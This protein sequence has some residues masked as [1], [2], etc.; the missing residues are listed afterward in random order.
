MAIEIVD[1]PSYKM[2]MFNSYVNVYHVYQR[3]MSIYPQKTTP[4]F[5]AFGRCL[6]DLRERFGH[7]DLEMHGDPRLGKLAPNHPSI[8]NEFRVWNV[9][10]LLFG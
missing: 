4:I 9:P 3:V 8:Q 6:H 5:A 10:T 1:L 2:V 7:G